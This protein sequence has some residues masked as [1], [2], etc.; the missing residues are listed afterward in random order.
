MLMVVLFVLNAQAKGPW[1]VKMAVGNKPALIG[2]KLQQFYTRGDR[3]F[4][5]DIDIGSSQVAARVLGLVSSKYCDYYHPL[6]SSYRI[7][8]DSRLLLLCVVAVA[9]CEMHAAF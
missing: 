1:V 8:F 2:T 4:E 6:I 7:L 3:F 9:R 5:I